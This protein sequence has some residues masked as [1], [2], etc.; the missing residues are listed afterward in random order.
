[1]L[2]KMFVS[3]ILALLLIFLNLVV[4]SAQPDVATLD[5]SGMTISDL[6]NEFT[7]SKES[8]AAIAHKPLG[9]PVIIDGVKY[10][11][12]EIQV[13]NGQR[14]RYV[15][16]NNGLLHGFTS[17]KDLEEFIAVKFSQAEPEIVRDSLYANFWEHMGYEGWN[18]TV[19]PGIAIGD[20]GSKNDEMS[21]ARV[22]SGITAAVLFEDEDLQ[23]DYFYIPGGTNYY[24]LIAFNDLTSSLAVLE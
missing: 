15:F 4:L 13:F 3:F 23:G 24:L 14:L 8:E 1:M 10:E 21:S 22:D 16:D 18:L 7:M 9:M 17:V 5:I 11:S 6:E 2:N 19:S 20:L 12:N